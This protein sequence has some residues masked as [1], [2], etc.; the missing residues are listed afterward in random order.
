MKNKT[1]HIGITAMIACLLAIGMFSL[2]GCATNSQTTPEPTVEEKQALAQGMIWFTREDF[3]LAIREYERFLREY[4]QSSLAQEAREKLA[5]AKEAK[6]DPEGYRAKQAAKKEA[7]RIQAIPRG[8]PVTEADLEY[9]QNKQG[10]ITITG[11]KEFQEDKP[12]IRDFV[13]PAQIQGINVTEIAG[14]AFQ[15]GYYGYRGSYFNNWKGDLFENVTIPSTVTSIGDQ[16]FVGRGIKTLILPDSVRSIGRGAFGENQISSVKWPASFLA[17]NTVIPAMIFSH[18]RLTSI[19]IPANITQIES[20]A[21]GGNKLTELTI[22]AN[23]T[24]IDACAFAGNNISKL[25]FSNSGK[26]KTLE[27]AVFSKNNLKSVALPE[28]LTEIITDKASVLADILG[29]GRGY[30]TNLGAGSLSS[31]FGA[32][33]GSGILNDNP[34]GY[35]KIPSTLAYKDFSDTFFYG[36]R[37]VPVIE[38]V[39]P[40]VTVI[41]GDTI[42]AVKLGEDNMNFALDTSFNN[43]YALQGKKAGIYMRRGQIWAMGTQAEFDALIAERTR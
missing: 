19:D 30:Y 17:G 22:P 20:G 32:S 18:N 8:T 40:R 4:P 2:I 16:A 23:V 21:F 39:K 36:D 11:Y 34:L 3:D 35:I 7:E 42:D 14:F 43:F 29:V 26:L 12:R 9:V 25:V 37:L 33:T 31:F 38:R 27:P 10:G 5:E 15:N 13:I 24:R 41:Q 1:K 6:N 28:G